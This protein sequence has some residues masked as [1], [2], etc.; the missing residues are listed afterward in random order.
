ME[1]RQLGTTGL[2]VSAVG[3]GC[4][5]TGGLFV[6][7]DDAAQHAA[8]ERALEGGITYFDTAAAYGD[9]LSEENLGRVLRDLRAAP[10]VGTKLRVAPEEAPDAAAVVRARFAEG[11]ARLGLERVAVLTIHSRLGVEPGE[12][13]AEV[14]TGPV[15]DALAELKGDGLIDAFGFTGL[16]ETSELLKVAS[17]GRF[18]TFQC[19]YNVL[20]QSALLP[21]SPDGVAQDFNGLLGVATSHGMG[22]FCIRPLAAGA[23]GGTPQ[24]HLLAGGSGRPMARGEEYGEDLRR[25]QLLESR[26]GELGAAALSEL[27]LRFA[28]SE[29]RLSSVLVGFS[30]RAQVEI[31]LGHEA[32]GAL[33]VDSL[34]SLRAVSGNEQS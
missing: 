33:S 8:T 17:S 24:R 34:S 4:G 22:A 9:G 7:G 6:R 30:D 15:A 32:L 10:L 2:V 12:L 26:L 28:L 20:N 5:G 14:L 19:Y 3:F 11:L 13:R 21:S 27:A 29:P 1:Y 25:A 31:A 18:D 16:G 23:L